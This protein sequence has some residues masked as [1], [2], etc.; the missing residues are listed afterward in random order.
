MP[1]LVS[2][3]LAVVFVFVVTSCCLLVLFCPRKLWSCLAVC[4]YCFAACCCLWVGG[5]GWGAPL[6]HFWCFLPY[7][8]LFLV[9]TFRILLLL[10]GSGYSFMFAMINALIPDSKT[11]R[12][13]IFDV[14][15]A[16]PFLLLHFFLGLGDAIGGC[17]GII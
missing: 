13:F 6:V 3:C 12:L 8:I 5:W 2:S 16:P 11:N 1:V 9:Q 4:L 17:N 15:G 7:H 10:S 14:F